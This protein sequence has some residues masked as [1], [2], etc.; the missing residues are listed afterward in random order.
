MARTESGALRVGMTIEA[1]TGVI[2]WTPLASQLGNF[3]DSIVLRAIGLTSK[4][5]L[6][7]TLNKTALSSGSL[8]F[9][10]GFGRMLTAN[11]QTGNL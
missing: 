5:A 1:Q 11:E 9:I 7:V 10:G 2:R 3:T 6:Q 8:I 4:R